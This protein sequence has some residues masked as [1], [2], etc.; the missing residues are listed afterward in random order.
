MQ[1]KITEI[2][3]DDI[4]EMREKG[5]LQTNEFLKQSNSFEINNKLGRFLYKGSMYNGTIVTEQ[6][7]H[8]KEDVRMRV[9]YSL[10]PVLNFHFV[11]QGLMQYDVSG[12]EI[13]QE[14]GTNTLWTVGESHTGAIFHKRD[15]TYLFMGVSLTNDVLETLVNRYPDLLTNFYMEYQKG[16][17][18]V[19]Q[20]HTSAEMNIVISQIQ[21]ANMMG[22][23]SDMFVDSKVLELMAL[24]L[25]DGEKTGKFMGCPCCKRH[26]DIDKIYEARHILISNLYAPPS[27][28]EL[29][30]QVGL[31]D[32]KLK[33]GF[34]EVFNQTVYG[35]LFDYK[36]ELALRLLH[37]TD[38][39]IVDVA[40]E[41]GYEY[42]SHF[43][44]AFK[45]K[46]G[47][48]PFEYRQQTMN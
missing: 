36:M 37:D 26:C 4:L 7:I 40:R 17:S 45:R 15:S 19:E 3:T 27:I 6:R 2:S 33:C 22:N 21:K 16:S 18:F 12:K 47:I 10:G 9:N 14:A 25:N 5:E 46:Y 31:N 38:K 39:L 43:S 44:T 20:R 11:L 28:M 48:T 41:C 30:R 32:F 42:A 24:Y 34:K 8:A 23:A 13:N 1:K 35:C 29:S